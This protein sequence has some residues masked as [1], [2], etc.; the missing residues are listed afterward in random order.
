[1]LVVSVTVLVN[2]T[3]PLNSEMV[4]DAKEAAK[5]LGIRLKIVEAEALVWA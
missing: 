2:L 1:V 4:A 5:S 3:N